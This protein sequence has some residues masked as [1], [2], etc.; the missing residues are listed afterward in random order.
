MRTAKIAQAGPRSCPEDTVSRVVGTMSGTSCDGLD[1]VLIEVGPSGVE[2]NG[3]AFNAFPYPAA[4]QERLR[5]LGTLS[6]VDALDMEAEWTTWVTAKLRPLLREW[7]ADYG[8]LHLLGFS[9]HTWYHE[10]RGRGTRAIGDAERLHA[11]LGVP[12]VAD[13]RSADVAAGGQGAPL[14]PL[15]DA[16]VFREYA[17]CLNL[18]G[19]AN[20]TVQRPEQP[21]RASDLCGCNLLLNRQAQRMGMPID[22]DGR[23]SGAGVV[24]AHALA[25]LHEW[26]YLNRPWPK[27]LAAEDL[28]SLHEALD[29]VSRPEDALATAVQWMAEAI[30]QG[31]PEGPGQVLVTGGGAHH[32]GLVSALR[33][34]LSVKG[35]TLNIPERD[36]VDGKEAA[37]FAWLAWR[38][39]LGRPTSLAS[40]TGAAQDVCGGVLYGNFTPPGMNGTTLV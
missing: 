21:V 6:D 40:V 24:D 11:D 1:V 12:V 39:A 33:S 14:V 31:C 34:A 16:V 36:W 25:Q 17:A 13:Y 29:A 23:G 7:A 2:V 19:I 3:L 9:G 30:S 5:A 32:S 28:I 8:P 10:P 20:V 18:G 35:L 27:S 26:D 15:F 22:Q 38:T 4:W 37:A